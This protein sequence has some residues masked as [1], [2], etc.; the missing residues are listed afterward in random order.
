MNRPALP[1]R[2]TVSAAEITRSPI[3]VA[4]AIDQENKWVT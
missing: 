2:Q 4:P 1:P 3:R